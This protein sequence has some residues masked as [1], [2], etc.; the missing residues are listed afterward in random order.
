MKNSLLSLLLFSSS[1]FTSLVYGQTLIM[2][3]ANGHYCQFTAGVQIS[4][5]NTVVGQT[6]TLRRQV[7]FASLATITGNG[8]TMPFPGSY[9][10]ATYITN[11]P[12]TSV[13]VVMDPIPT[14]YTLV[15]TNNG[16]FCN[17]P[18]ASGV[19]IWIPV[20]QN[21]VDYIL[22]RGATP[23]DTL[24]GNGTSLP[25]GLYAA[26][27]VYRVTARFSGMGC[28]RNSNNI[29]VVASAPPVAGFTF[30][31]SDPCSN[32]PVS[33]HSTS[34][35]T[36]LKYRWYFDDPHSGNRNSDTTANPLHVFE[37]WGNATETFQV[38]LKVTTARGCVDSI[39]HSVTLTQ[40]PDATLLETLHLQNPNYPNT[41][42]AC[43]ATSTNTNGDFEFVNGSTTQ[44]TN[45]W[46]NIVWGEPTI[47][48]YSQATFSSSIPVT[49]T[50][51]GYDILVYTVN[52]LNGCNNTRQYNVF[53]GNFAGG[54]L[55]NPG[56][57]AGVAEYCIDFTIQNNS[58]DNP[59][60]TRFI[61]NWG[62]GTG[63]T[64]LRQDLP[65]SK[66][67]THCYNTCSTTLTG[68]PQSYAFL[69][70]C[71]T[72]NPCGAAQTTVFP[73]VIS[74]PAQGEFG[75]LA[76]G[77]L[78]A[79]SLFGGNGSDTV[80]GCNDVTF[81]NT[82]QEGFYI[83]PPAYNTYTT[84][85]VYAWDFGDPASGANNT[86]SLPTPTHHFTQSNM[87]Y[88]VR[89]IAFTGLNSNFN[90]GR[91]TVIHQIYIQ[92]PPLADFTISV[93][94][95]CLPV[96]AQLN[97]QSETGGWGVPEYRWRITPS[98]GWFNI[99]P[100]FEGD[101]TYTA[102]LFQF[103]VAGNYTIKLLVEN[104]C[105]VSEKDT[106]VLVCELPEVVFAED[107][108]YLCGPGEYSFGPAYNMNCDTTMV[109][110]F[111]HITPN[112][113]TFTGGTS[114]TSKYPEINFNDFS[115]YQVTAKII[116]SC[117]ADSAIQNVHISSL[118]D[119]NTISPSTPLNGE[120]CAGQAPIVI[121]GT[122]PT[123]GIGSYT[124]QW[125]QNLNC[126]ITPTGTWTNIT[127]G[128]TLQNYT[129]MSPLAATRCYRR[130]TYD[131][132]DCSS[133]SNIAQILVYPVI[134]NNII[135]ASQQI[136]SNSAPVLLTGTQA[137]GGS[138]TPTYQWEESADGITF[139]PI[140]GATGQDYQPAILTVTTYFRR[141]AISDPCPSD[142]STAV[143][144]TVCDP[145]LN[146]TISSGQ[147]ICQGTA[148]VALT[149]STAT[150]ACNIISYQWQTS[151]T[152][153]YPV[154]TD[155]TG[156]TT[157]GY[158]PPVI[159]SQTYF[160]R[161]VFSSV[162]NCSVSN[163]N[164]II[165]DIM[166]RPIATAGIDQTVS[167]GATA[168]L[169]GS[170]SGGTP[171]YAYQWTPSTLIQAPSNLENV[172]TVNLNSNTEFTLTVTD[173]NGCTGTDRMWVMVTG[174]PLSISLAA[175]PATVC[176][177]ALTQLCATVAGGSG[178]YTYTWT[179]PGNIY[180]STNCIDVNPAGTTIY[181]C[182]VW[183]GFVSVSADVTIL[184]VPVPVITS[185][186]SVE[187]CSGDQLNYS[188]AS[189]VIGS[190]YI[191]TSASGANC[192]GN[193]N[194]PLPGGTIIGDY[195]SNSGDDECVVSYQITPRGPASTFCIGQPV[196]LDVH[197][198]P[199]AQITNTMLSQSVVAGFPT[200]PVTFTSN[201]AGANIRWVYVNSTCPGFASPQLLGDFNPLLPSQIITLLPGA[202]STC[203]LTYS[204]RAFVLTF[205]GDTCW[206]NPY[207]YNYIVNS[208][209]NKYDLI[210]PLPVCSGQ[211]TVVSL[212]NSDLGVEYRLYRGGSFVAPMLT[213]TGTQ[214]DW[215]G[216]VFAG[217]YTV[218][219]TNPGNGQS[220]LMNGMCQ[221]VINP[222]PQIFLLTAQ[223][224][225]HCGPVTPLLS[226]SGL[227]I[228]YQ[229]IKDGFIGL[230]VQ[231]KPG[232]G[233]AGFLV[234]DPVSDS[235]TYTVYAV[236]PLTGC[237][238]YMQGS[239]H[240]DPVIQQF[241]IYPG[242]VLCAGVELCIE[243]SE[244]GITYQ[245]WL[246]NQPF[247]ASVPGTLT[248]GPICFGTMTNAGIYRI[249]AKNLVTNCEKFFDEN[250]VIN[251]LPN[252]Y[253][254]SPAQGCAG[255]EIV[256]NSCQNG[257]AYYLYYEASKGPNT[258]E[259]VFAG[260]ILCSGGS[261]SF[262][263]M[264]DEGVYRILAVDTITNCSVWMSGTTT[265][266]PE[267]EVYSLVPQ[268]SACPPVTITLNHF[269]IN[270]TYYLYRN[271]DTLVVT[272][273]A[274][275]GVIDFGIQT[276]PGVYTVR[277]QF[278]FSGGFECW[279]DMQGSLQIYPE[280]VKYT[281]LPFGPL[282]PPAAL[283]LNGSDAGVTY[284]LWNNTYGV[285]QVVSGGGG[286]LHFLPENQPG[287]Y[288]VTAKT[289][290][291]CAATM[292]GIITVHPN[293]TI[294][295]VLP[296]GQGLCE[297][298][299]IGLD[300]S[301]VNTIYEL[302]NS[303]GSGLV[304]PEIH[305]SFVAGP[306]WFTNPQPAGSYIVKATNGFGCDTTMNGTAWVHSLPSVDAGPQVDTICNPPSASVF[307]NGNATNYSSVLWSSPTNPGGSNFSDPTNVTTSY[308]FTNAD[309]LNKKVTLTFTAFGTGIC[310]GSQVSDS[311]IIHL[312]AP[313]VDAGIDQEMC[314]SMPVQLNGTISGGTTTG[315]WSGGSGT[316]D[317]PA[318]LAAIYHPHPSETGTA[319]VLTLTTTNA[320]PCPDLSDSITVL[321]YNHLSAGTAGTDQT[322]CY[323]E[324]PVPLTSTLPSGGSGSSNFLYQ[325][326]FSTDGGSTWADVASGGNSPTYSPG[327]LL[328]TT[329]F[330]LQQSDSYCSPN[331]AV[332]TNIV[333]IFVHGQLLA[334]TANANQTICN[335]EIP[336]TLNA[337]QPAG[338][339]GN[340][341][342]DY[343]WQSSIDGYT[344]EDISAA[345]NSLTYSPGSL[346]M[347]TL[348][349]LKQTDTYCVPVQVDY[350]N[351]VI[352][353]VHNSLVAG[354][355]GYDQ[356]VCYGVEPVQ[357]S[358]SM[359]S[360]GSGSVNFAYQWQFSTDAGLT[361][362]NVSA[363]G[364]SLTFA[365]GPMLITT[366]YRL[367]QIDTYCNPDQIVIT[368]TV[369]VEV[370]IPTV[371]AGPDDKVCGLVPY[372]L[373][374][375]SDQF[376]INY[377][378]TTSGSGAF[379]SQYQLNPTYFPS[380]ADMSTGSVV[381]TLTIS[382]QCGNVVSDNITLTLS[383]I[384]AAF[385]T[386]STPA[387]SGTSIFFNDLSASG[388]G[389]IK[390]WVWNF[391]DGSPNDTINF[392]EN[393]N[394][395]KAF[396][397]PGTYTVTLTVM[398]SGGC[399]DVYANN[400]TLLPAPIANFH[401]YHPCEN[402]AVEFTDASYPNGAGN[403]ISWN[404]YFD[405]PGTGINNTSTL[406]NPIHI[407]SQGNQIYNVRLVIVNFNNCTDTIIKQVFIRPAPPVDFTF[408][409][410]CLDELVYFDPDTLITNISGIG[411]WHWDFGDG[412][413]SNDRNAA[414]LFAAPGTYIVV[415]NV[416]DTAGC[417]N[418]VSHQVTV[419]SLPIAHFDAGNL[420]CASSAVHFDELTSTAFGYIVKWEWDF[421][422]GNTQT[423]LHP[424]NPNVD[425]IY[426]SPGTYNVTLTI[427]A[428]DS[429]S[430]SET[431]V[432]VI[433]PQPVANFD[434]VPPACENNAVAFT[435]LT[436]NNGGGNIA[437][438]NWNFDDQVTG[439][440]NTS[441]IQ[442]PTHQFS[443]TGTFNVQLIS[444]TNNG[445]ADT[446]V[447][448]V[449]I[450]AKP[451]VDF[452]VQNNC[453]NS[454]V[455]FQPNSAVMNPASI[456]TW[457]WSFGDGFS[458]TLQSPT[459]TYT[460]VGTFA[461]ILTVIDTS[462]C[463]NTISKPV[464]IVPQPV[465]NFDY[466]QPACRESA[467][468]FNSLASA[469]TGYIVSWTWEFG[470][471]NTLV[472]GN[473]GNPNV[474]HTYVNYGTF[475]VS[476]TVKTN[477]SCTKTIIKPV[478]VAPN[479][480][481]NFSYSANCL[482]TP[483]EFSDLSQ[484]GTGI[485]TEWLWNFGDPSTGTANQSG[486]QSPAH[487]FSSAG[488]IFTISLIVTNSSGCKDTI[489][490]QVT[491]NPLP[492]VD[493]SYEQ[494]CAGDSTHFISSTFVNTTNVSGW[495]WDFGDGITSFEIDPAHIYLSAGIFT[496]I[497][498]ITGNDGC[499][500]TKI[501]TVNI[502]P[503]PVAL[504]QP[505]EQRCV[506]FPVFFD[507]FSNV[508]GTQFASWYWDFGDGNDTL[509]NAP[510]NPDINH[511]YLIPGNFTVILT[512]TTTQ[513]C[514]AST[515]QSISISA[516]P[517][518]I[519]DY[520]N[521]CVNV[522]V[523]FINQS[524]INGGTP[525]VG[526]SWNFGD[527]A[528]GTANTSSLTN[529]SHIYVNAGTYTV[530]LL[531]TNSN[532]CTD[533][534]NR[535][536]VI[537]PNPG[538]DFAWLNTCLASSTQFTVNASV[539]NISAVQLFDWDF[540]DGSPHSTLQNPT[541]VY[542][543]A[544][545]YTV[546][547][548]ITDTA[549]CSNLK[550]YPI[551][552]SP[553]PSAL[554]SYS[555]FGCQNTPVQ[556]T[557]ESFVPNG[558]PIITWHWDFGVTT[559]ANDTS[560]LQNPGWAYSLNGAYYVSLTVTS[561]TG[562]QDSIKLPIQ[563]FA[564]PTAN[565]IYT[566]PNCSAAVDFQDSSY[567]LQSS[568]IQWEWEFEPNQ[569]SNLPNPHHVFYAADSCYNVK[570]TVTDYKGCTATTVKQVCIPN[571]LSVTF[572]N[573]PTCHRDT[574]FFTPQVLQPVGDSLISFNWNFGDPDSGASNTSLNRNPG[575]YY[576]QPGTYTVILQTSDIN[577]CIAMKY[578]FVTVDALPEPVFT[579]QSGICDTTVYFN[580]VSTAG[581]GSPILHWIWSYDDGS[582]DTVYAP[583]N[584]DIAHHYSEPGYY[585]ASLTVQNAK[586]CSV[587]YPLNILVKPCIQANFTTITQ[588]ICQD[589]LISFADSSY[590]GIPITEQE[591]DFGDG[592]V[593][594]YYPPNV[595][596]IVTHSFGQPG[597]YTVKLLVKTA[598]SGTVI[599]DSSKQTFYVKPAP[600]SAYDADGVC[601][602]NTVQFLN[603]SSGNGTLISS[604]KWIFGDP[605]AANDSSDLPDPSYNYAIAGNY[606]PL[607]IVENSI[608]CIDTASHTVSVFVLPEARMSIE[609]PCIGHPTKFVD[610]SIQGSSSINNW[611]WTITDITGVWIIDSV[612]N[613]EIT[614]EKTGDF[615][616]K[617]I[618][619][620]ANGCADTISK[621]FTELVG[622]DS[623]FSFVEQIDGEKWQISIDNHSKNAVAYEWDFGNGTYSTAENPIATFNEEGEYLIRLISTNSNTC[624]DT[625][626]TPY[627][628][629]YKG[630][631]IPTAFAPEDPKGLNSVFQ[632]KGEGLMSFSIQVFNQWGD[633]V[634]F[635][636][637]ENIVDGQP[638]PGWDGKYRG[639]YVQM[640]IYVWVAS[641]VFVDGTVWDGVSLGNNTNLSQK[642]QGT[643]FVIR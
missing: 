618:V 106:T 42:A 86:S 241:V 448:S 628:L 187:I 608:G 128:G 640:G 52:G 370:Q 300:G 469:A 188:P 49:Y 93:S 477:D 615:S 311:I 432:L 487:T 446:V 302:L 613:T 562:C 184:V 14:V 178:N 588:Q 13:T 299:L 362:A 624:T 393:P 586:D 452:M 571:G 155:I 533:T 262:G 352:I 552:I 505:S 331:Q 414:H 563:V 218:I 451:P 344:W 211:S 198:K 402:T 336:V 228:S 634:W 576:S 491:V 526:S 176:P 481:A 312:L 412:T 108:I 240:V 266:Y 98:T 607:L 566:L 170:A 288:W 120:I 274:L 139:T 424:D 642:V 12:T 230:P 404:W 217:S 380:P 409:K 43:D 467:I 423:V 148:P 212:A 489:V 227:G 271:G 1:I 40:K 143:M 50:T 535:N 560:D 297:P 553:R 434:F 337:S 306:F 154:F 490:Q 578:Q 124:Y 499:T 273:N 373:T 559:A 440:N 515:S 135:A 209:P 351:I 270:A 26:P 541:H 235:G 320:D 323:G 125:Q 355:A 259:A 308:T 463:I 638:G 503:P 601:L 35:G 149:G 600:V 177:G 511:I 7:P 567:S 547:L 405:D 256:L 492:V 10:A 475:D 192:S 168:N 517:L 165:I 333:T 504:F 225:E 189:T 484:S 243:G 459:H 349:R 508:T 454:G 244:P 233:S 496:V 551:I 215:T 468:Q 24:Q 639:E 635:S 127:V 364:N 426:S 597:Y 82:T 195:L 279:K 437:Q 340:L 247:G 501:H 483:V 606:L 153:T 5:T 89:L 636:E 305:T 33:F 583:G 368:N 461:V 171:T 509:I 46:Y 450:V 48:P 15:A 494:G 626:F 382:D 390:Q 56:L 310:I 200:A 296:S 420:N 433:H 439:V 371:Y 109:G 278:I 204:V 280:P 524:S 470:D 605:V 561:Q 536:V 369:I 236:N 565:F 641:A 406:E 631:Y 474:V 546:I 37:A 574:M 64:L 441:A 319:V 163:S 522:P 231:T 356:T 444:V 197:V 521:T 61:F 20:S 375:A 201:V 79:N 74:C 146:N 335:G 169:S 307:L 258:K 81:T 623:D 313:I 69:A 385:F 257:I 516:S 229:L 206:G 138:G 554:F 592:I 16:T 604:Y 3:P 589:Y 614:F 555:S 442:N 523:S 25:F 398:N 473:I 343:Q 220:A 627:M 611:D 598:I 325:W 395:W 182:V 6:Y 71:Y 2:N 145:I 593:V 558:E 374:Q 456:G 133:I 537:N 540:G 23:L 269:N 290:D 84:N 345:G 41:F 100:G 580:D 518:A 591:W 596:S 410:T 353:T 610:K 18:S 226:G 34:T 462:G 471:G 150:G 324:T 590:S 4:L 45:T 199:I 111:W 488:T 386:F 543:A 346:T 166:P 637:T 123:G 161:I 110:Y 29:T 70:T 334:G 102:P 245:L 99:T 134:S 57:L 301:E 443:S 550:S 32:F 616:S 104:S 158:Q 116:N 603:L 485:I 498:T 202:P 121:G 8:G 285:R 599:S 294:F 480:L 261:L 223:N 391:G 520:S 376:A 252:I 286:I 316:F 585:N 472:V 172:T 342:F 147:L 500:N 277:A 250:V 141:E 421:G 88:T 132:G 581:I 435:D 318:D 527:P 453:Q 272:D 268:G 512:V 338:G 612:Q 332:Y 242:G 183:D 254:I 422:D 455:L 357:L 214:L 68:N 304:P 622:P 329:L 287:N 621:Q 594:Q 67:M 431:Q 401:F 142:Y 447:R 253:V 289:G 502:S 55:G 570:L 114:A 514:E 387:C 348:Y 528:S 403:V 27:G 216:I 519:F 378:W 347:T 164:E 360:G 582:A 436:Q 90:S 418:S 119:N 377:T 186:L 367:V 486:L 17:Y 101:S 167:N 80:V 366:Y 203:T 180:P 330:R 136:C 457:N 66:L 221:V 341:N 76:S 328:V 159:N 557:D 303:D 579:Y 427:K 361:W 205:T 317:D 219:A 92:T 425:H 210:C 542:A 59:P 620:D 9:Q 416:T 322:I 482:N 251:P 399:T 30:T 532:G 510:A 175:N 384:P 126:D 47:P 246:N 415:L 458:S 281:L 388:N 625:L 381:L 464:N 569:Y 396:S 548:T 190:T 117:G 309:I 103:N 630:L 156:V 617:L 365:P 51:L 129:L 359:P 495:F 140:S 31:I 112:T 497:L 449:I 545:T 584:P 232:T 292:Y 394:I 643:L 19:D 354:T 573:T 315:I 267:P 191:W 208:E 293:P 72:E 538:V 77:T 321:I 339:S 602:G 408:D 238:R 460:S 115:D 130:I 144:I 265:I 283:F 466:S 237:T 419:N 629:I 83:I 506:N 577:H 438:W 97:D 181:T 284:T 207:N 291:S 544:D 275:D 53:V 568:I 476:L 36:G 363:G 539:T 22:Y 619:T 609:N 58:Y 38:K 595:P 389:Y 11:P 530:M 445:C 137:F 44:A 157:P 54:G 62:D 383:Q 534:I 39:I 91:D 428:S 379:S 185:A 276:Q 429:C 493:F 65:A 531:V 28:S 479:P 397:D 572:A 179:S 194:L 160:R 430:N 224:N 282:C 413:F 87:W 411:S 63:D 632:P 314:E 295:N 239:I 407:F 174:N 151:S 122:L 298:S 513:G 96:Q 260:P 255:A 75:S 152:A 326:Q 222:L 564:N 248:G 556:F 549:G 525:V 633:V 78:G 507:D 105:G 73:I 587:S 95:T 465:S 60:D 392:P 372:V 575:H 94:D 350:T 118:I 529:P 417:Q 107:D 113:Y 213:G 162:S 234:F 131:A 263:Q 21:G 173:A 327:S 196:T 400:V 478:V 249:H 193:T 85:T 264:F 358:A